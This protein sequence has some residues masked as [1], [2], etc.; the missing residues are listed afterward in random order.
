MFNGVA[1]I[2][3]SFELCS[4]GLKEAVKTNCNEL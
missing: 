2:V 1:F 4:V 3:V